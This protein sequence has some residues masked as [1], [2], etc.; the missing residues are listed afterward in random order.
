MN[1][2]F[3]VSPSTAYFKLLA[4][5]KVENILI[6]YAFLK[7]PSNLIRF[8]NGYE[9]K[10]IMIDSGAFSVWSNGG[11]VDIEKY[12]NFCTELKTLLSPNIELN[13]VN[14]DVLPGKWGF[15]PSKKE[16]DE[17]AERGWQNMLYLEE[18]GLKVIHVFHQHEDW[19][20]LDKLCKHSDYI[21]ISPANDVGMASKQAWMNKVFSR[22]RN[23]VKTHGFAVTSHNQ[24]YT[25]PYYSVDSSSWVA[26]ARFGRITVM[27]DK[28]QMKSFVYKSAD[29]IE[30]FW[31]Y[32]S[33]MGIEKIGDKVT[34]AHRVRISIKAFQ[35]LQE[36]ATRLWKE[37]G[38]EW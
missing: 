36:V 38:V 14:L 37:R 13:V 17:S 18:K 21:G 20:V 5:E 25:F 27:D 24:L 15:V 2:Y 31:K 16:I 33:H 26:P 8:L 9:P 23:T 32:I 34:W 1:V 6:S 3:A 19:E 7:N 10:S 12:A 22:I 29:Q 4:E 28:L 11:T 30:A 35:K